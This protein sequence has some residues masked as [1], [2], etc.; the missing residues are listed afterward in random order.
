MCK[1]WPL[2]AIFKG[3]ALAAM[4]V[5]FGSQAAA[6]PQ[7]SGEPVQGSGSAAPVVTEG[8]NGPSPFAQLDLPAANTLRTGAGRPGPDYWQQQ[9]DYT[10]RATLDPATH[11][12]EGSE[13]INYTNRSPDELRYLWIQLDGNLCGP[14]SV[15]ALLDQPPLVFG[16]ALFDFSCQG[17]SG[18]SLGR[19]QSGGR[20]L[21]YS[22]YGTTMRVELPVPLASGASL[23]LELEWA[24][25]IPEYGFG[26]MG[27]DGTLYQVANWYPRLAVYDD[28]DGWNTE[29]F[30][31][32]GEYYL[33]YGDFAVELTLPSGYLV[34]ATGVLQNPEEVLTAEQRQR[35]A[36]ARTSETPV[37]IVDAEEARANAGR[38][39]TGTRTW[40]FQAEDV[41][42]FA[43]AAAPNF[44]WDASAWDG[45][46]IQTLYRPE[47]LPWEE[48]NRMSRASIRHFSQQLGR[49]PYPHATTVEGPI[50]G[51]EYPM[52]T[53]VPSY[54]SREDLFFVL[55]HEFGHEW[56]P[57]MVGSNERIHVWMDEGF[58]T[59][60]DIESIKDYFRGEA[61]ADT[62]VTHLLKLYPEHAVPGQELEMSL[63]PAEQRDLFWTAYQKPALMLHLLRT[64]VIGA[65]QFDRAFREYVAAWT[66]KHP[67]PADFFRMMED[68]TGMDL[69]WFW[70]GWLY[71]TSRLD[72]AIESVMASEGGSQVLIRNRGGMLMPAE[73]RLDFADGRS[74]TLRL[75]VEMWNQ[76]PDFVYRARGRRVQAAELDPRAVYPDVDRENN[77]WPRGGAARM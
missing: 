23:E 64:E 30:I 18:V 35:L 15:S 48:A 3:S 28:L 49:Y 22:V 32:P 27:R 17:G 69:D 58:N 34:A 1:I 39:H 25:G 53:F 62:V 63:P 70:R 20:P 67:S 47:A 50:E 31:G 57:M 37:A 21:D 19:V 56:F 40:R 51:M 11:R 33:E 44:R 26:R 6:A 74:E 72:Q 29:P 75:P 24:W 42:D 45:I 66:F 73:L 5:T 8:W 46:L 2:A 7:Q 60:V 41:R 71:S 52:L 13:R 76:G 65:E 77:R 59:F 55:T 61:Y 14:E 12:L 9:V 38:R 4:L 43:F 36:R 68:G 54:D 10:I 16:D